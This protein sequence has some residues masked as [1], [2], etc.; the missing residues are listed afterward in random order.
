M[1]AVT[2]ADPDL[3]ALLG[4]IIAAAIGLPAWANW[5]GRRRQ[6][7]AIGVPNGSG[8]LVEMVETALDRIDGL[9]RRHDRLDR[10]ITHMEMQSKSAK[11]QMAN[12]EDRL[13]DNVCPRLAELLEANGNIDDDEGS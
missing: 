13:V 3:I 5:L 11:A 1:L 7:R 9:H 8:T 6:D 12:I 2:V 4:L 10:R